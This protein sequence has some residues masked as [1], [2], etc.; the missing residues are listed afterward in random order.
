MNGEHQV[1][2]A[3]ANNI[4]SVEVIEANPWEPISVT[5]SF[6]GLLPNENTVNLSGVSNARYVSVAL[7]LVRDS[8]GGL[9]NIATYLPV[10]AGDSNGNGAVNLT[11]VSQVK[12]QSGA[13]VTLQN[14]RADVLANGS[15]TASDIGFTKTRAGTRLPGVPQASTQPVSR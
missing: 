9:G 6:N 15:I 4:E 12:S 10:L 3:F 13:T 11:D 14:F 2:F 7:N 8:T 5:S 1:V